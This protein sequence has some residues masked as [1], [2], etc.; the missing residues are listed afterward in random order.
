MTLCVLC[1]A[2]EGFQIEVPDYILLPTL[3]LIH[4]CYDINCYD[5]FIYTS[6]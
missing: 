3:P 5:I 6:V 4:I 1:N 2:I